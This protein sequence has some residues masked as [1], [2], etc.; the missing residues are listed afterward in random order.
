MHFASNIIIIVVCAKKVNRNPRFALRSA[1]DFGTI[2][3]KEKMVL[4]RRRQNE[5]CMCVFG[6]WF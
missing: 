4:T 1:T 5:V 2:N 3:G 6:G